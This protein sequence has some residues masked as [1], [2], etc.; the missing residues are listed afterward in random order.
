MK[1]SCP[2]SKEIRTPFPEEILCAFC[3]HKNEIWSDEPDM[4]CKGCGMTIT[5][6]MAPSCIEWCAAAKECVGPDKYDR[7][8]SKLRGQDKTAK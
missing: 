2:G 5:R 1:E 3:S 7:L 4:V 6:D 8:I